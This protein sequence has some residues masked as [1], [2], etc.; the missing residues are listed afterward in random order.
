VF[1][2]EADKHLADPVIDSPSSRHT[3]VEDVDDKDNYS[4]CSQTVEHDKKYRDSNGKFE[5][6]IIGENKEKGKEKMTQPVVHNLRR[7]V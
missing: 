4:S 7:Q 6:S 1:L 5:K 3:R 2:A